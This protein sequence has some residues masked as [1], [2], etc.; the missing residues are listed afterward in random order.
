MVEDSSPVMSDSGSTKDRNNTSVIN[1]MDGI[2]D[3]GDGHGSLSVK[4][5]N[6]ATTMPTKLETVE[7]GSQPATPGNEISQMLKYVHHRLL[8]QYARIAVSKAAWLYT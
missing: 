6:S 8:L 3:G 2:V 7:E 4:V 1:A 5:R